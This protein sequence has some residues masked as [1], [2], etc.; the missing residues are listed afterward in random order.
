MNYHTLLFDLDGT[1]TDP[2]I[3]I[4]NSVM[5]ALKYFGIEVADRSELYKF[6]GPPLMDSFAR[7]YG[8][9]E[10]DCKKATTYYREYYAVKGLYENEVY[11]GIKDMLK[12]LKQAGFCVGMATSKPE[13]F[14]KQIMEHFHL[15]EYFDY[16]AGS[17][18]DETRT[19]KAEV[20]EYALE[21]MKITDRSG[22]LMIGD[23]EYDVK[24]AAQC[25]ID[26]MGVLFGYGNRK[27]LESAGTRYIATQVSDIAKIIL[28]ENQI[29]K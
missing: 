6:I 29:G 24:G 19:N 11:D 1:I 21:A 4:T 22:V 25:G 2:G 5:H 20:I 12:Q 14:A 17:A 15:T 23:R 13:H 10:E 27:E 9:S 7:F 26:C 28:A 3:G 8:F 16:I 18:M